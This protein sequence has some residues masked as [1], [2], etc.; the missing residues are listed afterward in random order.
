MV[1]AEGWEGDPDRAGPVICDRCQY[2]TKQKFSG[3]R[4]AK[5]KKGG[6]WFVGQNT[7]G[8]YILPR[9]LRAPRIDRRLK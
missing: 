6:V 9:V 2:V 7:N 5:G 3:W 1:W 8:G 4:S